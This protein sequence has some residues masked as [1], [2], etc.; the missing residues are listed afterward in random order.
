MGKD[1]KKPLVT[2]E[3]ADHLLNKV[4][5]SLN[6]APLA[7]GLGLGGEV[8]H[9]PKEKRL[10]GFGPGRVWDRGGERACTHVPGLVWVEESVLEGHQL[11]PLLNYTHHSSKDLKPSCWFPC[12]YYGGADL[13]KAVFHSLLFTSSWRLAGICFLRATDRL[14]IR[15]RK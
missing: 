11:S 14:C 6:M 3:V 1:F 9:G 5:V 10:V 2:A 7:V 4:S 12:V 15:L 13:K 8:E